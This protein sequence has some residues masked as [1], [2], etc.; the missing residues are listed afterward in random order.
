MEV[1]EISRGNAS[2]LC[3]ERGDSS[4][5]LPFRVML[6]TNEPVADKRGSAARAWL[7]LRRPCIVSSDTNPHVHAGTG[8]HQVAQN[9]L[10]A[11]VLTNRAWTDER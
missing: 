4:Q 11:T 2:R 10:S 6:G 8:K 5:S 7:S 9:M 1:L 3:R